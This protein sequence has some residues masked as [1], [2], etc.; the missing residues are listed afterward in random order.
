M[1]LLSGMTILSQ[2]Y[3]GFILVCKE[4]HALLGYTSKDIYQG[5]FVYCPLCKYKNESKFQEVE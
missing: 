5:K 2:T 1:E 3:P 4:C